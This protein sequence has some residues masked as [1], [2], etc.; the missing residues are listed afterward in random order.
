MA[1]TIPLSLQ[2]IK[3]K[4]SNMAMVINCDVLSL[5]TIT[6]ILLCCLCLTTASQRKPYG[7]HGCYL[8]EKV[9]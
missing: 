8:A 9:L 1:T 5:I 7:H 2:Q 4:A 6:I 3:M